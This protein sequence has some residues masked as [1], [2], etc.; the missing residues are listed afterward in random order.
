[1]GN[2]GINL[3]KEVISTHSQLVFGSILCIRRTGVDH[4]IQ[5]SQSLPILER[6]DA[7]KRCFSVNLVGQESEEIDNIEHLIFC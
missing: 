1:M 4:R 7:G 6:V 5:G 3:L 2:W